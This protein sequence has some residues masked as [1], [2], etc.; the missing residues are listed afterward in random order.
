MIISPSNKRSLPWWFAALVS[1]SIVVASVLPEVPEKRWQ[2]T[3]TLVGASA[4]FIYFL[5][6]QHLEETRMFR[7][8]FVT[9][10]ERYDKL[11]ERLNKLVMQPEPRSLTPEDTRL[12]YDYFNLCAEEYYFYR[13]GYIP[14]E[15]WTAWRMGMQIFLATSCVRELLTAELATGSY[16]GLTLDKIKSGG[17]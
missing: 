17:R 10:N 6:S 13:L 14:E 7:E 11:N 3:L 1:L 12:L 8:L 9:F 16:Y 2:M 15:V 5:Y 4:A